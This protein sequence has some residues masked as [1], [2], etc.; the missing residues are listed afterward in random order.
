M[1]T[2]VGETTQRLAK[3][4]QG[5]N[6]RGYQWRVD[7]LRAMRRMVVENKDAVVEAIRKDM[8]RPS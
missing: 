7:Q 2:D 3:Y 8:G 4:F 6:T 5:G 1:A